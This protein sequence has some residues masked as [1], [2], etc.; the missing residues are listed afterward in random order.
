MIKRIRA[1][2]LGGDETP[3]INPD[4]ERRAVTAA[5]LVQAALMDG[6]FDP[7]ERDVIRGIMTSEF[8]LESSDVDLLIADAEAA[9]HQSSQLFGFTRTAS[10]H[11]DH[12]ERVALMGMLWRV[13]YADGV[14]HDY[15]SNLMRRIAGLLHVTDRESAHARRQ[16]LEN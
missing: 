3:E 10:E 2:L 9:V 14:V 4:D 13:V 1:L 6:E 15:E 16:A 12:D 5:L 7:S 11:L 8:G